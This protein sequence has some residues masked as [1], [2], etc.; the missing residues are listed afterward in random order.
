MARRDFESEERRKR[1]GK[2]NEKWWEIRI[3]F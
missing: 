3:I 2:K 1:T